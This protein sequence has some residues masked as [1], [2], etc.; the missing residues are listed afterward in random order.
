MV[1][2]CFNRFKGCRGIATRYDRLA[3]DYLGGLELVGLLDW[4]RDP[5][6]TT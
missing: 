3:L 1:G 4:L 5:S 6:D 2:R